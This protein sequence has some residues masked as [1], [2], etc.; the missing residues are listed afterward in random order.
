MTTEKVD[1]YFLEHKQMFPDEKI[2]YIRE[3]ML[4]MDESRFGMVDSITFKNPTAVLIV[5]ILVGWLG[6]DRFMIGDV[7]LGFLKLI[8]FGGGLIWWIVDIFIT[9]KKARDQN[10]AKIMT[11]I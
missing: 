5:S 1:A 3:K 10:F 4:A 2:M 7:G 9:Y 8:T 6:I 11:M